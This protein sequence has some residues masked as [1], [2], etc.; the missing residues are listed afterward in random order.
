M[1]VDGRAFSRLPATHVTI[2]K[3]RYRDHHLS[4]LRH[5]HVER[6]V[7]LVVGVSTEPP[8]YVHDAMG[9]MIADP[10]AISR[11]QAAHQ[12]ICTARLVREI[13]G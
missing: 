10:R 7:F 6:D 12:M 2:V 5:D 9:R 8:I 4:L 11:R 3:R 1:V 13:E